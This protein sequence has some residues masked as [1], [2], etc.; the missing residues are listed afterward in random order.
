[1]AWDLIMHAGVA[2]VS[3]ATFAAFAD[4]SACAVCKCLHHDFQV[5]SQVWLPILMTVDQFVLCISGVNH[6]Q[7][8]PGLGY[9]PSVVW[10]WLRLCAAV[11][12]H[13]LWLHEPQQCTGELTA[14]A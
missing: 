5:S 2:V 3:L 1:V 6:R 14:T 9:L 7:L 12:L 4:V 13:E 11:L 10:L 8:W